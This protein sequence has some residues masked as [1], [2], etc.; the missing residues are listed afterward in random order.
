MWPLEMLRMNRHR[1]LSPAPPDRE[2]AITSAIK[3]ANDSRARRVREVIRFAGRH[4]LQVLV[5]LG[6]VNLPF[7]TLIRRNSSLHTAA[8]GMAFA[9]RLSPGLTCL[10][11]ALA[12]KFLVPGGGN[13]VHAQAHAWVEA[14][15]LAA[16]GRVLVGES[17]HQSFAPLTAIGDQPA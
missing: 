4:P 8:L 1:R 3:S 5:R 11:R 13:P 12:L 2:A 14:E 16:E 9:S 17:M 10:S 7:R 15:G 6:L